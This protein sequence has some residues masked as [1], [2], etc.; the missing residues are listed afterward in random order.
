[1]FMQHN[2]GSG[3]HGSSSALARIVL[4]QVNDMQR[5]FSHRYLPL[6]RSHPA[7]Q[8]LSYPFRPL[9]I[10]S[11]RNSHRYL[12]AGLCAVA[13]PTCQPAHQ[14][15]GIRFLYAVM[16]SASRSVS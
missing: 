7:R 13:F 6:S 16:C 1:M 2:M 14:S 5:N 3:M 8:R 10:P 12:L 11:V 9:W 4:I 15:D